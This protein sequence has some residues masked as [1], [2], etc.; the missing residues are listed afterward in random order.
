MTLRDSIES[1]GKAAGNSAALD[2][3]TASKARVEA[4]LA[5]NIEGSIN[6]TRKRLTFTAY[7]KGL[8]KGPQKGVTAGARIEV[9]LTKEQA[10]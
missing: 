8:I 9:D 6:I 3:V 7:M 5:G 10:K 2:A 4:D 1:Q